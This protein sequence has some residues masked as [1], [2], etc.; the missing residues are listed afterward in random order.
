[1]KKIVGLLGCSEDITLRILELFDQGY[2]TLAIELFKEH[3]SRYLDKQPQA[4]WKPKDTWYKNK[5]I[6]LHKQFV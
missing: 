3:Y 6:Q 4:R 2:F 5:I 1:M